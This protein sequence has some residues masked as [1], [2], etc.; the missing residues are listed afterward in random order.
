MKGLEPEKQG[1]QQDGTVP[2]QR[3]RGPEYYRQLVARGLI[4]FNES[5]EICHR[6]TP[7]QTDLAVLESQTGARHEI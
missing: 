6:F 3:D 7:G 4:Y 5:G 2:D 1:L